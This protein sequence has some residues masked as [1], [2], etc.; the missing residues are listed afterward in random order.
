[1]REGQV[2]FTYLHLAADK[3]LTEELQK[4]QVTGVAYETVQTPTGTLP[5]LAPMSE[6]AGRLAPQ[7]GAY[8]LMC[9]T[10]LR[11][12]QLDRLLRGEHARRRAPYLHLRPDQR[13]TALRPRAGEQ[14]LGT[15]AERRSVA[16]PGPEHPRRAGDLRPR[17]ARARTGVG[18]IGTRTSSTMT[19][20]R[21]GTAAR[22]RGTPARNLRSPPERRKYD[23]EELSHNL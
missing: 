5:L 16:G 3:P 18:S 20:A 6:V 12:A 17:R 22:Y 1:M 10:H 2:L 8:H 21:P 4:R 13:H 15:G 23:L 11:C 14:G 7:A 9:P 19:P